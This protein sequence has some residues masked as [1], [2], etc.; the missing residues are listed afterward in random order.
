MSFCPITSWKLRKSLKSPP[1]FNDVYLAENTDIGGMNPVQFYLDEFTLHSYDSMKQEYDEFGLEY[2]T[3]SG[4]SAIM[5]MNITIKEVEQVAGFEPE[6][7]KEESGPPEELIENKA[8][9]EKAVPLI[10]VD[11]ASKIDF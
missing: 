7:G 10:P 4:R 5:P 2:I 11:K 8:D 3:V 1:S 9:V 6:Y